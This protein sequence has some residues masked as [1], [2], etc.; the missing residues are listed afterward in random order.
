MIDRARRTRLADLLRDFQLGRLSNDECEDEA[1]EVIRGSEDRCLVPIWEMSWQLYDDLHEHCLDGGYALD[2]QSRRQVQRWIVFLRS[3]TAYEW[4]RCS[5]I[6]V[7]GFNW[8]MR[9]RLKRFA[10]AGDFDVWLFIRRCD[11]NTALNCP[12][13]QDAS[14]SPEGT[15]QHGPG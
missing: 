3:D 12:I 8:R 2:R 11:F 15:S 14:H 4:P 6:G 1:L 13:G 10:R 9:R 5:F 7:P